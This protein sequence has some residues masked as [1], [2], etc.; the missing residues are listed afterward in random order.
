MTSGS[1]GFW[2]RIG[3][4][5]EGRVRGRLWFGGL[6]LGLLAGCVA[7]KP[8]MTPQEFRATCHQRAQCPEAAESGAV[9]SGFQE[10]VTDYYDGM[11]PCRQACR[12][13]A[14]DLTASL[15]PACGAAIGT[16]RATCLEFCNRKFYRC[17]CDK[18]D[19]SGG[20]AGKSGSRPQP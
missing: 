10:T 8:I 19:A 17:N 4:A 14:R 6:L 15:G 5:E 11:A 1:V 2:G 3:A 16:A 12:D 20:D 9:C 13:K 18:A 7:V